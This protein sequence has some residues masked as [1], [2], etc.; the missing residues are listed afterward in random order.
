MPSLRKRAPIPGAPI[1]TE[2]FCETSQM[3]YLAAGERGPAVLLLHGWSSFKEIWW[4]ALQAL[5]PHVRAFAPDMPGHGGT[6][7]LGTVHMHQVAARAARFALARGLERFVL[8]GHSMGGNIAVELALAQ[9]ALVERLLLADPAARPDAMPAFTRSY[10]A[11]IGGW[12]SLRA[13]MAL[14]RPLDRVA[15]R[16]P[17]AHG[18]GLVRPALRRAAY[19]AQHDADA[20][21]ALLDGLFANPL[22]ERICQLRVPTLVVSGEFDPLVPPPLSQEVAR[23]IP[24][25]RY[26]VIRGAAHNPMDER[27]AE[28][29]RVLLDFIQR[30]EA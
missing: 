3:R 11:P 25:A 19:M 17:H 8:V 23:L 14:A 26:A 18:G 16:V 28:P 22:G 21:H 29:A 30:D 13:S 10:L 24:G 9:P 20:L 2:H 5:A 15:R 1:P 27:P 12:L 7:L 6:P 4:S